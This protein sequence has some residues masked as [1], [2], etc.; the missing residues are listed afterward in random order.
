MAGVR[1]F[2]S[3]INTI[4]HAPTNEVARETLD[5]FERPVLGMFGLKDPIFGDEAS[6]NATRVQIKGAH[7][8]P[9]QDFPDAGHFIQED[10]G[11][12]LA[13]AVAEWIVATPPD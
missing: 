11:P 1:T 12:E 5:A 13:T 10:A 6:R 8:Q 9:H 7:G 2:P 3:L 4:G